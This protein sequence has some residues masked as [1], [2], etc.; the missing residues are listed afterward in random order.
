[1]PSAPRA[2]SPFSPKQSRSCAGCEWRA[3]RNRTMPMTT[4]LQTTMNSVE[5]LRDALELLSQAGLEEEALAQPD[6]LRGARRCDANFITF[7]HAH[8]EPPAFANNGGPWTTWL[9]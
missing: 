6:L 2:R 8:Q 9:A 3:S 1:M 7:A 5:I 4:S